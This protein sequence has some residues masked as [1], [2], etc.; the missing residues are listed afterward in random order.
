[1]TTH[2]TT[3]MSTGP[4]PCRDLTGTENW[5]AQLLL[6]GRWRHPKTEIKYGAVA[7]K[8]RVTKH[9]Y[10]DSGEGWPGR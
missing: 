9:R 8:R 2:R 6:Y 5:E 4:G 1:M 7:D 3:I 10:N